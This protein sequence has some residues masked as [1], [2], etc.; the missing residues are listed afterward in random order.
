MTPVI[1]IGAGH[2]GLAAA[3]YLARAGLKPL[4]L[5]RRGIVGGGAVTEEI[6]PGF[7]CP[8]LS[9]DTATIRRDIVQEMGLEAHGATF[10]PP[11]P[12]TCVPDQEG[13]SFCLFDDPVRSASSIARVSARDAEAYAAFAPALSAM[14]GVLAS[15]F[16]SA[17]PDIEAPTAA[18]LW[19]L[20]AA[21]R[22]FRALG[23]RD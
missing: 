18:D 21:G 11:G 22:G 12:R 5:E 10:L 6:A 8:T 9:H 20:L 4:V 3:F 1:I 13:R 16:A 7:R 14:A 2:N 17:P 19:N 15:L 23:R